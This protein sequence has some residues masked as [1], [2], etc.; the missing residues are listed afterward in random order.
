V[1]E[2]IQEFQPDRIGKNLRCHPGAV[3]GS[4]GIGFR[5]KMGDDLFP[6]AGVFVHHA[7]GFFVGGGYR[8]PQHFKDAGDRAFAGADT[9]CQSDS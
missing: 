3:E 4:A 8:Y 6:E 1:D 9:A 7:S 5:S 2:G